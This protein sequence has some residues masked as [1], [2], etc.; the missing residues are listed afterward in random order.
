M[1]DSLLVASP[2]HSFC[3]IERAGSNKYRIQTTEIVSELELEEFPEVQQLIQ[4]THLNFT[5]RRSVTNREWLLHFTRFA[6][7]NFSRFARN[8]H[9]LTGIVC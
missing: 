6:G 3:S 9:G 5:F 4:R 1:Y 8:R 7:E 2:S